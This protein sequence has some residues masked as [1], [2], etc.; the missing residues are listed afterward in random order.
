MTAGEMAIE[1]DDPEIGAQV[2]GRG[3]LLGVTYDSHDQRVEIMVGDAIEIVHRP[4]RHEPLRT[5]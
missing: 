3:P 2:L 4:E 5:A 1:V